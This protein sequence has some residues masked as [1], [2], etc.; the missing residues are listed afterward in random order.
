[1]N[2]TENLKLDDGSRVAVMGCGPAGSFFTYFLLDMAERVGLDIHVDV[3]EPRDFTIP[4]PPGCN[5][6]GGVISE[7]LVQNLSTEGIILPPAVVQRGV[8][9]YVL[10]TDIGSVRIDTP[11]NEKRIASVFRG[12]GPR[13]LKELRWESFDGHLQKLA[14]DKGAQMIRAR[15]ENIERQENRLAVTAKNNP[16]IYDLVAVTTGVN[17]AALKLIEK[18]GIAYTPPRTTKTFIREY[19]LGEETIAQYLGSSMHVFLLNLPRLEFAM[20][21][22]K[23]DYVTLAMLGHEIDNE[24]VKAFVHSPTF[25]NLMPPGI[26]LD[27]PPCQCQPRMTVDGSP[28]PFGDRIVFIGDCGVTRLYK[29]GIGAAYRAAKAAATTVV[30]EGVSQDDFRRYYLPACRRMEHDNLIG[31]FIF[32]VTSILQQWTFARR[33]MVRMTAYEQKKIERPKR[34]SMVMWDMFTGSA[35]YREIF[36]RMLHPLFIIR[37][38]WDFLMAIIKPRE[39]VGTWTGVSKGSS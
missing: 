25:A 22:P 9:S 21:V 35:P 4:G 33:A 8:D 17:T 6:C 32:F 38:A 19:K 13:D 11:L 30:F 3:Y 34:M 27:T 18:L 28:Q 29:D 23:G 2:N 16:Q 14:M 1:M 37:L 10:H 26:Q 15:V 5:M 20:L 31:K 12:P 39:K 36:V 24:L 7:S